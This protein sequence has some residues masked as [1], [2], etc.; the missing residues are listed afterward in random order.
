MNVD[1]NVGRPDSVESPG[2][3]DQLEGP[4]SESPEGVIDQF[5]EGPDGESPEDVIGHR[6]SANV[7]DPWTGP[8]VVNHEIVVGVYGSIILD[9]CL[10]LF[11]EKR[12]VN[13][14]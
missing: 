7:D 3:I 6:W 13:L 14:L 8:G 11:G 10:Y 9:A 1:W 12:S 2:V 5:E 4:D